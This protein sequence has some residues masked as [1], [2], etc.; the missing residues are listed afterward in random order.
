MRFPIPHLLLSLLLALPS[1][2]D[3]ADIETIPAEQ[4]GTSLTTIQ[5]EPTQPLSCED[6]S[7]FA[8]LIFI[9]TDCPIANAYAPE[10]GRLGTFI[11]EAGGKLTLVH[12]DAD[13]SEAEAA[14]H[15]GDYGLQSPVVIDRK[16]QLVTATGATVTPEAALISPEGKLIYRGRINDLFA[17]FGERRRAPTT[18]DLKHAI[19]TFLKGET[20]ESARIEAVG[21]YIPQL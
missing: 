12:V 1:L 10:I 18:H 16:H 14:Q 21:C 19:Q 3:A 15:A 4:L 9:T 7:K 2:A 11:S 17:D 8:A 13:R 5:G 6:G 20:L